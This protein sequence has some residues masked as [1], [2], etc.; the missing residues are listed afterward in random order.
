M[1]NRKK[2]IAKSKPK[3]TKELEGLNISINSFGEIQSSFDID[4]INAFLDVN[5]TDPKIEG[6]NRHDE[7]KE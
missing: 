1:G 5:V 6:A 3:V 2:P 4:K 7:S